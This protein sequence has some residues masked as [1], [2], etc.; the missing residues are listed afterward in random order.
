MSEMN[1]ARYDGQTG[2]HSVEALTETEITELQSF[3][4]EAV[5]Y[6]KRK[7]RD[8]LL[9]VSDLKMLPD[10]PWDTTAWATYRQALRDLPSHPDF[11][12]VEFPDPPEAN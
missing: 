1:I 2:Q 7:E 8:R 10:V 12:N 3:H 6:E 5:L 4:S 11:P 9:A